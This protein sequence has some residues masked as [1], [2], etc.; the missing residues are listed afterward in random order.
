MAHFENGEIVW[1]EV[2]NRYGV[3]LNNFGDDNELRL[4][5][6]GIVTKLQL[7][8]LGSNGDKG[9][10]EQLIRA[11]NAHKILITEWP[12]DYERINY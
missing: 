4:D 11:I 7:Y 2:N 1:D 10:K 3:V 5:S 9:T 6:D 8:K 12:N